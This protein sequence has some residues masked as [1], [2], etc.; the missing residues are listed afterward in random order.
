MSVTIKIRRNKSK[1]QFTKLVVWVSM[2]W[3]FRVNGFKT[4]AGCVE[5]WVKE[6]SLVLDNGDLQHVDT[7]SDIYLSA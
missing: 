2:Y 3:G 4:G 1:S 5:L 7:H 6:H